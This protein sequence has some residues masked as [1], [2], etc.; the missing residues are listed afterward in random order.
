MSRHAI[1]T[2]FLLTAF[3]LTAVAQQVHHTSSSALADTTTATRITL[4]EDSTVAMQIILPTVEITLPATTIVKISESGPDTALVADTAAIFYKEHPVIDIVPY[5]DTFHIEIAEQVEEP[6]EEPVSE[7]VVEEPIQDPEP[8]S[9]DPTPEP[10]PVVEEPVQEPVQEPEPVAEEPTPEPEPV[11]EEPT[12][13]PEPVT[14]EPT[15]APEPVV[16]EP[17]Q[18]SVQE[19]EPVTEEPTPESEPSPAQKPTQPSGTFRYSPH[20]ALMDNVDSVPYYTIERQQL[21]EA[22][23]HMSRLSIR[24]N[25]TADNLI[26]QI[27]PRA[28][29][30]RYDI[31][32]I[33]TGR[34]VA[35]GTWLGMTARVPVDKFAKGDYLLNIIDVAT[36]K[37][38]MYKINKSYRAVEKRK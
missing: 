36:G 6:K 12:P 7:P 18:E 25:P 14:E 4:T 15:P 5:T 24:P 32:R 9:E 17:V 1:A 19:P 3:S 16:E 2:L 21:N 28:K 37:E 23:T 26:I 31:M 29:G 35:S 13:E 34:I 20:A 10:E 30:F 33:E 38:C 22:D 27:T 8:V 11:V